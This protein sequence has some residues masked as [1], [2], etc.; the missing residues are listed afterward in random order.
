MISTRIAIIS[1][2]LILGACGAPTAPDNSEVS[3]YASR[4][5][6]EGKTA[7]E[8]ANNA[9]PNPETLAKAESAEAAAQASGSAS[10]VESGSVGNCGAPK[11]APFFG[12]R[13]DDQTRA[14]VIAALAPQKTVRFVDTGLA[15][16]PNPEA[17]RLN[18]IIDTNGIIR[19]ARCG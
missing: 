15:I 5:K 12:R 16:K 11:V 6:L 3:D 2:I 4:I 7:E 13:A 9:E 1:S 17:T 8:A 10:A 19:D 18:V 14:A